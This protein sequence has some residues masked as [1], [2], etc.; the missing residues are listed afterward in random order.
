MKHHLKLIALCSALLLTS[1]VFADNYLAPPTGRY[2]VGFQDVRLVNG[3]LNKQ[4]SYVCPGKTDLLYIKGKNET[5]FGRDNQVN[6]CREVMVRIYYPTMNETRLPYENY[7]LPAINDLQAMIRATHNPNIS[8]R[9]IQDLAQLQTFSINHPSIVG[10]T[11]PVLFFAPGAGCEIQ[12]YENTI[13]ELVSHG[14]IVIGI[15]NTFIGSSILFP[16]GRI[17][18]N[19]DLTGKIAQ[20]DQSV[21]NDILFIKQALSE[22]AP[23]TPVAL[24]NQMDLTQVGLF[25]HSMGGISTVQAA[26]EYPDLFQAVISYDSPP[27]AFGTRDYS[28]HALAGFPGT[29]FLRLFAAEWRT[30]AGI[31]TPP[32]AQFELFNN[33]YYALLAPS[34]DNQP[35]YYTNHMSFSDLSTLQY[36]P[37]INKFFQTSSPNALGTANGWHIT[38]LINAY[39]LQFFDMYLKNKSSPAFVNCQAISLDSISHDTMLAC[40]KS[41]Q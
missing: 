8:E 2:Q 37:T 1:T 17:V 24:L 27:V 5:D 33:N 6:F 18:H 38:N 22:R 11:F 12:Q 7:Y 21:L 3:D 41:G 36:Q 10:V 34:E 28:L 4:G 30:L 31:I 39:T 14:Y 35:P 23:A 20:G 40:G 15:N 25:G 32:D 16:D 13:T 19:Q 29:P 9:D 26:R